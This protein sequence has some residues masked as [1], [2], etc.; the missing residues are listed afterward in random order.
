MTSKAAAA[1]VQTNRECGEGW[2]L[3]ADGGPNACRVRAFGA[4]PTGQPPTV[5]GRR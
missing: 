2:M 5:Q 3:I 1:R 4:T